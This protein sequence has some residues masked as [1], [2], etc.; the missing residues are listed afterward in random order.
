VTAEGRVRV[1]S[2]AAGGQRWRAHGGLPRVPRSET[3]SPALASTVAGVLVAAVDHRG[4][5]QWRRPLGPSGW[6]PASQGPRS[7]GFSVSRF[8]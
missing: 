3:R 6:L 7:G 8:L 2:A 1:S 4:Q 5:A